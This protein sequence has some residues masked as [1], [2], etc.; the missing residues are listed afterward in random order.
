MN[1]TKS[2]ELY[3]RFTLFNSYT[4]YCAL[5][6][7]DKIYL[8]TSR[9]IWDNRRRSVLIFS[10]FSL[11]VWTK[12]PIAQSR[13]HFEV[14]PINPSLCYCNDNLNNNPNKSIRRTLWCSNLPNLYTNVWL[15]MTYDQST[16]NFRKD[17]SMPK[18]SWDVLGR[19]GRL[20]SSDLTF[21]CCIRKS[22]R[23]S[24]FFFQ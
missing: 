20:V 13:P 19:P 14:I 7:P 10:G 11:A 3:I 6:Y 5:P 16:F 22:R 23:S 1:A 24:H 21:S 12:L 18:S 17:P 2:A 9:S 8:V 4:H 15:L